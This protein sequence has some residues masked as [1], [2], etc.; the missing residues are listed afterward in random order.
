MYNTHTYAKKIGKSF[1]PK[2]TSVFSA[3]RHAS[4]TRVRVPMSLDQAI[5]QKSLQETAVEYS[6]ILFNSATVYLETM[7]G[8]TV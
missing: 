5:L 6:L 8:P 3:V 2:H 4:H 1:S 7:P